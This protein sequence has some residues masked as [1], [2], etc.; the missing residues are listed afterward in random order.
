M[1]RYTWTQFGAVVV[2]GVGLLAGCTASSSP[3][4]ALVDDTGMV[5]EYEFHF[6]TELSLR[7]APE[8]LLAQQ[9]WIVMTEPPAGWDL[10]VVWDALPC[11]AAPTVTVQSQAGRISSISVD[12]GPM[13]HEDC[14]AMEARHVMDLKTSSS[15]SSDIEL[16]RVGRPRD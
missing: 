3:E 14:D 8:E 13:L 16:L 15:A 10:R 9:H 4:P 5:E 11:E 2:L 6:D 7:D 12:V 1:V